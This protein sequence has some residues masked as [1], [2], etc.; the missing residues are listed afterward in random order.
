MRKK[1]K[2]EIKIKA[3]KKKNATFRDKK[4][5][6]TFEDKKIMQPFGTKKSRNLS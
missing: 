4:Y 1:I 5:H 3:E 6:A 2:S